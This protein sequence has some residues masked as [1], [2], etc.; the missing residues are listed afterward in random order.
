MDAGIRMST[1]PLSASTPIRVALV[2]DWLTGMRGGEKCLEVLAKSFP[3]ATLHTLIHRPGSV[4]PA[5]EALSIKTSFLQKVPG[6]FRHY[7]KLLPLMP[8]AARTWRVGE[9]DLVVSLSHCVA[10][11]VRVPVGIPH[12]CYCF[13]PMRYAWDGRDAYLASW[14][15]RSIKHAGAKLL[16]DG[17]R[18][19][20]RRSSRGVTDFIAISETIRDRIERCYDRTSEVIQPPVDTSFYTTDDSP[21]EDFYLCVSALVPYKRLDQAVLACSRSG[22]RLVVIGAGPELARLQRLAG[23]SVSF[24]GW[25]SDEVIRDHYRRCRAF[26]FP[27]EEDFGIVPIEALACG[28]SVIA[29]GRGGAAETIDGRVGATYPDPT[30]AGLLAA[31]EQ[32]EALGC[33]HD[34]SEGRRRAE[35]LDLSMF[36]ARLLSKLEQVMGRE[37]TPNAVPAPHLGTR[38]TTEA[39]EFRSSS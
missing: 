39:H 19:W 29:L 18:R 5:I 23:P 35:S 8:A 36:R 34:P 26:L 30:E 28:S 25:Q 3:D 9:V 2:H 32:W 11:A 38:R 1:R 33:P 21:R 22:R 13:T 24:L 4:S 16:L 6:I 27:G 17:L 31:I 37:F 12:V 15:R 14:P 10:K 7:R 20:D